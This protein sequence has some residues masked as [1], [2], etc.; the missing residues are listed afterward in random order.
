[1][2]TRMKV[3]L[4]TLIGFFV[5]SVSA[6]AQESKKKEESTSAVKE[7]SASEQTV[8]QTPPMMKPAPAMK[9][10]ISMDGNI[11]FS[12]ASFSNKGGGMINDDIP[13]NHRDYQT[14][15]QDFNVNLLQLNMAANVTEN[16]KLNVG[17]GHGST[18]RSL[19]ASYTEGNHRAIDV[20]NANYM[21]QVSENFSFMVGRFESPIGHETY[22]HQENNQFTRTY[23][24]DLAPYFSTGLSLNYGQNMWNVGLLFTNGR[25]TVVDM[26]DDNQTMAV[27]VGLDP[28]EDLNFKLN[29]LTGN[30]SYDGSFSESGEGAYEYSVSIIDFS[31]MY[32]ISDMFDIAFNYISQTT[33]ADEY[34]LGSGN[35]SLAN[36]S[37]AGYVNFKHS[38]FTLGFRYERFNFDSLQGVDADGQ[39]VAVGGPLYNSTLPG[40]SGMGDSNSVTSMTLTAKMQMEQNTQFLLE[41]RMDTGE[42]E[43]T[44]MDSDGFGTK[45]LNTMLAALMYSF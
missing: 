11:A 5:F 33:T 4:T 44:F 10:Q 12:I 27:T 20:L 8:M 29:Y 22:N 18:V 21:M 26:S 2:D 40:M 14:S 6:F 38:W 45:S 37:M 43:N 16:S 36:T 39:A 19:D 35:D 31:A 3:V 17:L 34:A 13:S 1:M 25:G 9:Q 7:T 42:D 24:F 32:E 23:G 28:L 30:E 15:H 41:Y